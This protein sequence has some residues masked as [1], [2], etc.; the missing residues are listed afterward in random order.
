MSYLPS[1]DPSPEG[2]CV[3]CA[4]MQIDVSARDANIYVFH[5]YECVQLY[6]P[7]MTRYAAASAAE[8]NCPEHSLIV[9]LVFFVCG[10]A[11]IE[12]LHRI[13]WERYLT[14]MLVPL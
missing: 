9:D 3:P 5:V 10:Q 1:A 4:R 2:T 11:I 7:I 13:E 12:Q 6:F 8:T 14:W